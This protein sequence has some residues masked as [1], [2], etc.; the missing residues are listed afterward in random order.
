MPI[1]VVTHDSPV[2]RW[3]IASRAP[4]PAVAPYVRHLHGF[5]EATPVP[6]R[7][8]E[9]P[10]GAVV[11]I[12]AIEHE[13]SLELP[14]G[15]AARRRSFVAGLQDGPTIVEH[16]GASHGMEIY[17]TP[18]GARAFLGVPLEALAG[19][20][21]ELE[22]ILGREAATLAERLGDCAGW[23][24]RF[25]V[26]E[27]ALARRLAAARPP[28]P[29]LRW[30]WGRLHASRGGA[31]IG[32]LAAELG[33][34]PRRLATQ[35]RDQVGMTPK[36]VARILR[37]DHAY[38]LLR[39]AAPPPLA[40]V[41]YECGYADQPHFTREFRSLAGITPRELL[42]SRLPGAGGFAAA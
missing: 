12:V 34:S 24:A 40:D 18:L 19:Q 42:A 17:F 5:V 9:V 39:A 25:D 14:G 28:A 6:L 32:A 35:F 15:V 26:L 22:D 31:P 33:W 41:A 13:W 37:F 20:V 11:V 2:G 23:E 10:I 4:G 3:E 1:S 29:E 8:R 16:D 7:R 36:R 38:G 21:L 30:A 27:G